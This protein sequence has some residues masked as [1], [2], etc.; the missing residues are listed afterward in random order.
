MYQIIVNEEFSIIAIDFFV[1]KRRTNGMRVMRDT[2]CVGRASPA[3]SDLATILYIPAVTYQSIK[4][5]YDRMRGIEE[6]LGKFMKYNAMKPELRKEIWGA[7][8]EMRAD[9]QCKVAERQ[10]F[11]FHKKQCHKAL[12]PTA[13]VV[14][15]AAALFAGKVRSPMV[16]K[17]DVDRHEKD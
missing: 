9:Y 15:E 14:K 10:Q 8:R 16:G 6:V 13:H 2:I 7:F 12:A 5:Q 17:V 1:Q 4:D 11:K 3:G